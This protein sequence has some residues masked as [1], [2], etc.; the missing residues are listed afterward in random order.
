MKIFYIFSARLFLSVFSNFSAEAL[1]LMTE[2][3][4]DPPAGVP[5]DANGDGIV[6]ATDDEFI[7]IFNPSLDAVDLSGWYLT[8]NIKTRH[9]F[10]SGFSLP[11]QGIVVVFGGGSP[12][13]EINWVLASTGTLSL[14]NGG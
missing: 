9:I 4:A 11:G 13:L 1:L 7:E 3:L 2:I 12:G 6:S 8:D 14:N 5:A 10:S